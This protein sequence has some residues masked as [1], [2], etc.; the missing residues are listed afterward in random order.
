MVRHSADPAPLYS[1]FGQFH[2]VQDL[3]FT[4]QFYNYGKRI[5]TYSPHFF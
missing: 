4:P 2:A 5:H 3:T 1:L